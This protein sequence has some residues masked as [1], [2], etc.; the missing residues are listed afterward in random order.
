M[1]DSMPDWLRAQ[2]I[3]KGY[4]T[5]AGLSRTARIVRHRPCSIPT[6]AGLD[7]HLCALSVHVDLAQLSAAGEALALLDGRRTY[8]YNL[9]RRQLSPRDQYRIA[10]NPA[11]IDSAIVFAEHRCGQPVPADWTVPATPHKPAARQF[12]SK[13]IPF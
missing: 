2:L 13:E 9:I 8:G 10:S 1:T 5:E 4:L 12:E 7:A 6:L 11:G 3:D